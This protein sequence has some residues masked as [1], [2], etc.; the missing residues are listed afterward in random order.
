VLVITTPWPQFKDVPASAFARTGA[1][2][3]VL[4]C[5]RMLPRDK[6]APIADIHYLGTRGN[7]S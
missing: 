2:L 4:D 1:R 3:Q 6:I 5:W 7:E